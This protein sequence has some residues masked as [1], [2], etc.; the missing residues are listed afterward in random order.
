[1][2]DMDHLSH[3]DAMMMI[4]FGTMNPAIATLPHWVYRLSRVAVPT[5]LDVAGG[6]GGIWGEVPLYAEDGTDYIP[7]W[8][9][10]PNDFVLW[11]VP[12]N[13]A[14][15]LAGGIETPFNIIIDSRTPPEFVGWV[16]RTMENTPES[17]MLI[18]QGDQFSKAGNQASPTSRFR[19]GSLG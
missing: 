17:E 18:C 4:A 6:K 2:D 12:A 10:A 11:E 13:Q 7:P 14:R 3:D 19:W 9:P 16:E 8:E 5:V 1:M 15:V